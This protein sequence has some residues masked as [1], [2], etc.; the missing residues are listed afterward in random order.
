MFIKYPLFIP[1]GMFLSQNEFNDDNF[2]ISGSPIGLG[3]HTWEL[4]SRN[5]FPNHTTALA[6]QTPVST[7]AALAA[8]R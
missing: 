8:H 1:L 6:P 4:S 5:Y 2:G 3:S 7:A